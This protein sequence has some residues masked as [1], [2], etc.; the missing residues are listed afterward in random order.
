MDLAD[1]ARLCFPRHRFTAERPASLDADGYAKLRFETGDPPSL[2]ELLAMETAAA[3]LFAE[4]Q[5]R[6]ARVLA[7]RT[8]LSL[9]LA[10]LPLP[11]IAANNG[12]RLAVIAALEDGEIDRARA[13]V[14]QLPEPYR[15]Q[16]LALFPG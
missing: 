6:S 14:E 16:A 13:E 4:E 3:V 2:A 9:W 8:A 10:A 7:V 11:V 1:I 12:A 5:A 15:A